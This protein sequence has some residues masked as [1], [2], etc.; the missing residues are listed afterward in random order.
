MSVRSARFATAMR[1]LAV[2]ARRRR[3]STGESPEQAQAQEQAQGAPEPVEEEPLAPIER[4]ARARSAREAELIAAPTGVARCGDLLAEPHRKLLPGQRRDGNLAEVTGALR[5]V[6]IAHGIVPDRHPRHRLAIAPGD[7]EAVLEALSAA[8]AGQAVYAD[9]L[10]H[11]RTLGTVLAE[12]L[13][14]AVVLM[15]EAQGGPDDAPADGPD[16]D[17]ASD[18]GGAPEEYQVGPVWPTD[19]V[20]GVR[21]YRPAAIDTLVYGPDTGCDVEFWDSAAP[22]RGAIASIDETPLGWWV[23]SLEATAT[24]T[25]DGRSYPLLDVF[26]TSLPDQVTFPV[27]AVITWVDDADPAWQERRAAARARLAHTA[28]PIAEEDGTAA[29]GIAGDADQRFRNRDELRYCL[30]A[31]A[32]HAPWIRHVYLVTDDQVPHWLDTD[33]PGL[34]VVS[35]RELFAGTDGGPVFNSHAIESR[36]HLIPGLAEHFLYVNDDVFLGRPLVPED[37]FLGNGLPRCFSDSRIVPPGDVEADDSVYVAAL[38]NT[39]AVLAAAVGKTY[40]RT[41]KHSPHPLRRSVLAESAERFADELHDTVRSAFRSA[42][43]LAPVTL[44]IHYA[45]ATARAVEGHLYDGYFVTDSTEDLARLAELRDERWADYFCL[46][47]GTR[48]LLSPQEQE[49]AVT[50]FLRAYFPVPSP[51]ETVE[52]EEEG[53]PIRPE[54]DGSTPVEVE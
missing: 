38:K 32:A 52:P 18:E 48:D 49:E 24:T 1:P 43:D 47:D 3:S 23:P 45:H 25:V 50:G 30:R 17:A 19:R 42:A 29:S 4:L 33:E 7:R 26:A 31:L 44:A 51:F 27:D 46:A 20:K 2:L 9:L 11:G 15:E 53:G 41:L 13:P 5:E 40:P 36:L 35:H 34:T 10:E 22:S 14:A 16:E 54:A 37:F 21:I 6:G 39:R 28:G 12:Q 8:F